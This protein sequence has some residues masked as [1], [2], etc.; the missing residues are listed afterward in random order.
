MSAAAAAVVKTPVLVVGGGLVGLSAALFLAY[1]HVP[2]VVVDKHPGSSLHPRAIGYTQRTMEMFRAVGLGPDKIPQ[3]PPS[4]RLKRAQVDSLAGKWHEATEFT[5]QQPKPQQPQQPQQQD[6]YLYSPCTGAAIAQD[7]VEPLLRQRAIELGADVRLSVELLSLTQLADGVTAQVK[8]RVDGSEYTIQAD[9]VVAADGHN[10]QVRDKVLGVP[11]SGRGFIRTLRSALFSAPALA[12]YLT[13]GISQFVIMEPSMKGS[14]LTTY[15][16]GRWVLMLPGEQEYSDADL[17][18]YI[19]KAIGRDD[20]PFEIITQGRWDLSAHIADTFSVGRIFLAGDAAHT[21]PPTRGGYGANTGIEDAHNLAWKLAAVLKGHASPKLL[22]TY[23]AERRPISWLRFHQ[24][25]ARGDYKQ[26]AS[27]DDKAPPPDTPILDDMAIE[28]GQLYWSS[29]VFD[30]ANPTATKDDMPLAKKPDEWRGQPGTRAPH[31]WLKTGGDPAIAERPTSLD[32]F[33]KDGWIVLSED[34]A[35]KDAVAKHNV[36]A[37]VKFVHVGRD[38]TFDSEDP[39]V[40]TKAFSLAPSAGGAVL[41]RPDGYIAWRSVDL[42]AD[43]A[44]VLNE[45]LSKVLHLN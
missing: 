14:F 29:A 20:V 43:P 7:K 6:P 45:A 28:V 5:P 13:R 22:D 32:L 8:S 26:Y 33:Q 9:Y 16:D 37:P 15:M 3:A 23:D 44:A 17:R 42:P 2:V 30:P 41:V 10:S 39:A 27:K 19:T 35:W 40:F 4:F 25:F 1:H 21:L 18:S 24:M 36:K 11:M 31:I 12:E 38:M 34:A